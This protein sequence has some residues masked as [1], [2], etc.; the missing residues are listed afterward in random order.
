MPGALFFGSASPAPTQRA[1]G[2]GLEG[3]RVAINFQEIYFLKT[4]T[5]GHVPNV[6]WACSIERKLCRR[7]PAA[8][9]GQLRMAQ[10]TPYTC[11]F[12]LKGNW[13]SSLLGLIELLTPAVRKVLGDR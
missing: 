3:A 4:R 12:A 2:S 8:A 9:T 11:G 5:F 13:N 10:M 6:V 7:S 1:D